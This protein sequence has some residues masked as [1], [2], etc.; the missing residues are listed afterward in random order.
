MKPFRNCISNA[1]Q[2][3]IPTILVRLF[4]AQGKVPADQVQD[5]DHKL[6]AT[7]FDICDP[8]VELYNAIKDLQ[9]LA[10]ATNMPYTDKQLVS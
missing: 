1:I 6:M 5:T 7:V 4:Q 3:P 10:K 9:E 2:T 8:L